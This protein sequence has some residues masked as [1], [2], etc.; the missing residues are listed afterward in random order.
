MHE[1]ARL[2]RSAHGR[3]CPDGA[4]L[5]RLA[6]GRVW[7]WQ[8]RE[9]IDHIA[10]CAD[11]AEDYRAVRMARDGL[12]QALGL[13]DPELGREGAFPPLAWLTGAAAAPVLAVLLHAS[14]DPSSTPSAFDPATDRLFASDFDGAR[15]KAADV[16][17]DVLFASDFDESGHG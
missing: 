1:L 3:R 7:P 13:P 15:G 17:A 12:V 8:R 10:E 4:R 16:P 11:C 5:A 9:L 14:L 6:Q 2:R